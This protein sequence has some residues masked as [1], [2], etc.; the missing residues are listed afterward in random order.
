MKRRHFLSASLA[1]GIVTG[2]GRAFAL[3]GKTEYVNDI[4]LQAYTLRNELSKDAAGTMKAVA[5]AGF[6][7]VELFGF[8]GA[9]DMMKAAKDA[10]LKIHSAHF[11]A[12]SIIRLKGDDF[13]GFMPVVEKA[14]ANGLTH[15]VIP[16]VSEGDRKTLDDYKRMAANFNKAADKAKHAGI[17][18]CYHNH[19]FEFE[20]KEG[21]KSGF[22]IFMAEFSPAMKFELDLF[23]V[24]VS[25]HEPAELI[26]KLTGRVEQL[27][28]KDVKEGLKM[29]SYGGVPEDSFKEV[30]SGILPWKDILA[31]AKTAGVKYCHVE[32]DQS[33]DP[34]ASIKQS[35]GYLTKL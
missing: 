4:G 24:K 26:K 19:D 20:P 34:L 22:E 25:G 27:H 6:K 33:P 35:I 5:E 3:G 23:W 2:A 13:S 16:H 10:G 31:A 1:A 7:H 15:L 30:G 21:G 9:D 12:D 11:E 8:P 28:L 17:Q 29:P 32:Q 14:K 18:L